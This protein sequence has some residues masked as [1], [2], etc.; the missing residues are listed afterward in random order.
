MI[1]SL[2]HILNSVGPYAELG[3]LFPPMTPA[4]AIFLFPIE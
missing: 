4:K 2:K 1:S 3:I